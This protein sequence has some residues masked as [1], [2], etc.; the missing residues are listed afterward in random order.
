MS[1]AARRIRRAGR[2]RPILWITKRPGWTGGPGGNYLAR[3]GEI[4]RG[5]ASANSPVVAPILHHRR[6]DT[7][8]AWER[9]AYRPDAAELAELATLGA[10]RPI[11]VIH[12]H[13]CPIFATPPRTCTCDAEVYAAGAA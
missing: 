4:Q 9:R 1:G 7:G 2:L 5:F 11:T 12:A 3:V 8:G 6:G 13:G 10:V